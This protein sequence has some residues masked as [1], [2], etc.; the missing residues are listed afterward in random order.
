MTAARSLALLY[1]DAE[2]DLAPRVLVLAANQAAAG[3]ET[4]LRASGA[5]ALAVSQIGRP[6]FRSGRGRAHRLPAE[7]GSD[8]RP[9]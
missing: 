9:S 6:V 8:P 5:P 1:P 4:P 7:P 3:K 2:I